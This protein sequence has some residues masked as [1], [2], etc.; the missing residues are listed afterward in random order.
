VGCS[1]SRADRDRVPIRRRG[2]SETDGPNGRARSRKVRGDGTAS[3]WAHQTR[4]SARLQ[5]ARFLRFSKRPTCTTR[6]KFQD[7][8]CWVVPGENMETIRVFNV[9][10]PK[11]EQPGHLS[12]VPNR[13][14]MRQENE[15]AYARASVI[16]A[17]PSNVVEISD[18]PL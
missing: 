6:H 5:S 4:C 9:D 2:L 7:R 18:C 8:R 13:Q 14:S 16:P 12:S 10:H 1:S 15:N 3:D 11:P 17:G